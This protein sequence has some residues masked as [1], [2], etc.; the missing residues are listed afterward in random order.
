M[1]RNLR[2]QLRECVMASFEV[3]ADKHSAKAAGAME[4]KIFSYSSR[5][6]TLDLVENFSKFMKENYPDCNRSWKLTPDHAK[7][8]LEKKA[9]EGCTQKTLDDYRD[10]LGKVA[11][12]VRC[13]QG[14]EVDLRCDRVTASK[15]KAADRGAAAAMSRADYDK[16]LEYAEHRPSG[17]AY[18]ILLE[19]RIGGRVTDIC[20]RMTV[21]GDRLRLVCK[22]GKVMYRDIDGRLGALLRDDRFAKFRTDKGGFIFPKSDS[23]NKYLQ[24]TEKKLKLENHSFHDI[25]RLLAQEHYDGLRRSGV[26]RSEALSQVGVW[27]NHG[28]RRERLVLD[29]YVANAW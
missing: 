28:D 19:D 27:L 23:V 5:G 7:A 22:G 14:I 26:S 17:S 2:H 11:E 25:R 10:R 16:L 29:S 18:A 12:C 8:F 1:A 4:G 21:Q 20:E 24:R 6:T 13:R 9:A 3:G 15:A